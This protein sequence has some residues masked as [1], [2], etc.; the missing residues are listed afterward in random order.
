MYYSKSKECFEENIRLF[1]N[2]TTQP[3]KFNLYQGL[4]LLVDSIESDFQQIQR[5]LQNLHRQI[6]N[7]R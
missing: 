2:A 7:L 6:S 1:A 3:E 4:R 5:E